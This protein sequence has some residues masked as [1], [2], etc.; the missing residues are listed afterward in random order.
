MGKDIDSQIFFYFMCVSRVY[1]QHS[2]WSCHDPTF[3]YH[4]L[5]PSIFHLYLTQKN[6][7]TGT[8]CALLY[9]EGK[10]FLYI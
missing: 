10:S 8:V 4:S 2:A 6:L 7:I 9:I 5:S 3:D 1:R